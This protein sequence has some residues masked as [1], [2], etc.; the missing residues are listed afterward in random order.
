MGARRVRPLSSR[1]LAS[2]SPQRLD[3]YRRELLRLPE[4]AAASDL[5]ASELARL[6]P[7]FVHFKDDPAWRELH[8]LVTT[9]RRESAR[10]VGGGH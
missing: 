7:R 9:T 10:T 3:A 6:D 8:E 4:A 2:L 1:V 5:S